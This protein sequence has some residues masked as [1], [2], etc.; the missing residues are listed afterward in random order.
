MRQGG[1]R[2]PHRHNWPETNV[3]AGLPAMRR[4]GGAR[5][6]S[7]QTPD[8]EHLQIKKSAQGGLAIAHVVR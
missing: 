4:A 3:G 7:Q 5:S 1:Q 2:Y 6:P 8:G